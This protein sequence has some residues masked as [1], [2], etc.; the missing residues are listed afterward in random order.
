MK[1][2]LVFTGTYNES[3]NILTFIDGVFKSSN[4]VDLLIIDDNSPDGTSETIN[5]HEKINKEMFLIKREKKLG[6]DTA[7]KLA[8]K[9]AKKK[10][11]EKLITLDADL[12]HDPRK[13]PL[14]IDL[15]NQSAFV[16]G[17]RY[18]VG[19]KNN[20]PLFRFM[21]SYFGNKL[22]KILLNSKL[23]EHT[24]SYRG[25]NL[26]KL[27]NFD[28]DKVNAAGYSFFMGTIHALKLSGHTMI[29]TPIVFN[30]RLYGVSKIPKIEIF[31]TFINLLK[32]FFTK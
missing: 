28:L 1:K 16:I 3:K 32:F 30:D 6:L 23:N 10:G 24:T 2:V 22:I 8:Y 20:Q 9:F 4:Q 25:F 27:K 31:R 21:L 11:Y 29:E 18:A 12:S 17:S 13:I 7:H 5:S 19:A 26:I 15:L 14:F